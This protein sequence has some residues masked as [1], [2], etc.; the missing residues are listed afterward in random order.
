MQPGNPSTEH[1]ESVRSELRRLGYLNRGF[2]RFLLQDAMR[3]RQTGRTLLLLTAKVGLIAGLALALGFA[4]LLVAANGGLASAARDL[5]VLTLHLFPPLAAATGLAFLALCG[6]VVLVLRLYPVRHVET[7][8]LAAAVAAGAGGLALAFWRGRELV[9]GASGSPSWQLAVVA[10]A[11]PAVIY[12]VVKLAYHGL[13][14]LAI[15]LT[16]APPPR[17]LFSRRWL[18]FA[19]LSGAFV[20]TLPAVLSARRA[21]PAPPAV[22]PTAPGERVLL[23][24]IDGVLPEEVDYLLAVGDL[25]EL[26]RLSRDGGVLVSYARR[27]EPPASLWTSV[28]TGL[29]TPDHGVTALDSFL[30]RGAGTPLARSGPLR[31]YWS[32]VEVPL[33]LAEHRPVLA[34]R[35]SAFAVW[36]LAARGGAPVAAIDWWSTF[37]AEPLPGLVVAHGAFQLLAEKTPG[38]VAPAA[39]APALARLAEEIAARPEEPRLAA[40]LPAG[41]A[42]S[43]LARA[44]VPDRFYR[45]VLSR[46]LAP[47][48]A[49]PPRAAALYLP[50]LDIAAA[51]WR[52]GDVAF[53]DLLRGELQATDGLL[54]RELSGGTSGGIGTVALVLDPGR[55]RTGGQ[56]RIILWRRAWQR[57]G[58]PGRRSGDHSAGIAL[59]GV[60]SALLRALG[61]P[62][63]DELPPPPDLCGAGSWPAPPATVAGYGRPRRQPPV[64]REGGEYLENLR[65]LGYI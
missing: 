16:D 63:S 23:V 32:G 58:C 30:P 11:A 54:A 31:A 18:G 34:N 2:E 36:E 60:A 22:L 6:L 10:V 49:N 56:G 62:Q 50:G 61:L 64:A 51:G 37:P 55:R 28:A 12:L 52:G 21:E 46:E 17:R 3:P 8:A 33:G 35:R 41:S 59:E 20:L 53:A 29:P 27:A 39:G 26:A 57:D 9:A 48:A 47:G 15:L 13:L 19:V 1:L 40:A 5:P 24:G 7:L 65:S 45:E 38:A 25:P 14:A 43:L 44:L 4:F 42:A